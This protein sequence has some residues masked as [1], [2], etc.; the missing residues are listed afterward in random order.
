MARRGE[1]ADYAAILAEITK[2]DAR[3]SERADAPLR[4]APDAVTLDTTR[5]SVEAA[6]AAA[7]AIV[8]ARR[9]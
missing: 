6:F 5:L 1:K 7:L 9:R 8:E 4:P 3:D 2:R